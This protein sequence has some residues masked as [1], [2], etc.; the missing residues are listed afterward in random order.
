V[1]EKLPVAEG[2]PVIAPLDA[3]KPSPEGSAPAVTANV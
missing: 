3:F 2:V 1:N